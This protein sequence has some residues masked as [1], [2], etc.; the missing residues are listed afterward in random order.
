MSTTESTP[1]LFTAEMQTPSEVW[2]LEDGLYADQIERRV[3]E[4]TD[5]MMWRAEQYVEHLNKT[6]N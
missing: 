4:D 2:I 1:I 5:E 6:Y 3:G